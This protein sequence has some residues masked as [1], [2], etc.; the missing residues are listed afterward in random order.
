MPEAPRGWESDVK[1]A[2][3]LA[4]RREQN[5]HRRQGQSHLETEPNVGF[6]P[7]RHRRITHV[8]GHTALVFAIAM[9]LS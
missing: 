6:H 2:G 5:D 3:H 1:Q 4:H 7:R 9:P 8:M